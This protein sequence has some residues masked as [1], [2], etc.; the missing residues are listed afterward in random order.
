MKAH[1]V[2]LLFLGF[3]LCL[4]GLSAQSGRVDCSQAIDS[5]VLNREMS[6]C[7][8]LPES[9]DH[10]HRYYPVLYLFHGMWGNHT[11]WVQSGEVQRTASE[12]IASGLIP[13]MIIVMPDGLI[14]GFYINNYDG[15]VRWEDFF[16]QEFLPDIENR[17]RIAANR[18]NRGL[19]GLS[20]G[21]Y[22][23][24]YHGFM[25]RDLFEVC[26]AL[27]A[28]VIEVDPVDDLSALSDFQKNFNEKLWGPLNAD[29]LPAGYAKHSIQEMVKGMDPY[30]PPPPYMPGMPGLPAIT[31]DCGDDDFLLKENV[32][33]ALL[34]KEKN[35]PFELRIRD[36]AHTW[37]YWR[38]G[39]KDA[40]IRVGESFRL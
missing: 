38:N 9:Y 21:G 2:L 26:Y 25:H 20:M 6:Y 4:Q 39:I 33:L 1:S 24:L 3:I 28:G 15:S 36:G 18:N 31:L 7:I 35:I 23:A 17:Y 8:Y 14:D 5:R 13:E 11:D 34:L 27:S 37:D 16:Y 19:A 10:S 40:L 12:L 29:K 32:H 30:S 22:G